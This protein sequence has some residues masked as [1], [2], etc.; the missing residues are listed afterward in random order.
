MY[1][2]RADRYVYWESHVEGELEGWEEQPSSSDSHDGLSRGLSNHVAL[3]HQLGHYIR[4][5]IIVKGDVEQ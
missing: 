3:G 5:G 1:I 4:Y 2:E